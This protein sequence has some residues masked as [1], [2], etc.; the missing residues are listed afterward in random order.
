MPCFHPIN[1]FFPI[2]FDPDGKRRLLFGY[3]RKMQAVSSDFIIKEYDLDVP[4][5]TIDKIELSS[6][7]Y[8]IYVDWDCNIRGFDIQVPCGKCLGCKFD[9]SRMW[10]TRSVHE[11]YMHDYYRDCSFITLTFNDK[12]LASS[13]LGYSL[14]KTGFRSWIKR[15]RKAV[16][17][18][19]GKTIRY[20]ACGEYGTRHSRPHYHMI[21][22]GFN[23]PDKYVWKYNKIRGKD[24][25]YYRSPFL[26]EIWTPA[27]SDESY[28]FSVIG[29]VNFE[30]SAYVARYVTKKLY[31]PVAEKIYKDKEPEFLLTS[32]NPGLGLSYLEEFYKD[33]FNHG[34]VTLPN[35]FKAPIPRYYSN[36]LE[37]ICPELY[38]KWSIEKQDKMI[39]NM[40][41]ENLDMT[42]QRRVVRE[43]LC[44]YNL[45]ILYRQYEFSNTSQEAI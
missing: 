8:P 28:G 25:I 37:E 19:Y 27:Y 40:F 23:F 15:F 13:N 2:K 24:V 35:G 38:V 20:M 39:E 9:Y 31:G 36:K 42:H 10:A 22:Y 26:E 11:A 45:D 32:R 4:K 30:T 3:K 41:I 16:Y 7:D 44:S 1:A 21:I 17:E 29:L 18:K 33:I 43:E 34:Y 6:Y 14:D 5:K 12:M